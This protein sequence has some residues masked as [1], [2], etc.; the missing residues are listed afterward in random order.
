MSLHSL[1]ATHEV[2]AWSI[3]DNSGNRSA[4]WDG[5]QAA[6]RILP[7]TAAWGKWAGRHR[8]GLWW[9]SSSHQSIFAATRMHNEHAKWRQFPCCSLPGTST[10]HAP[11]G[12]AFASTDLRVACPVTIW[13][14]TEQP[15]KES[16]G[17]GEVAETTVDFAAATFQRWNNSR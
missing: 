12:C 11:I 9:P 1:S 2:S 15:R 5:L 6:V 3:D 16:L 7:R 10:D 8:S 4:V 14:K 17:D 13:C